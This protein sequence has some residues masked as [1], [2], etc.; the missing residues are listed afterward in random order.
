MKLS[1]A[2]KFIGI[3]STKAKEE[4]PRES[5]FDPST[6]GPKEIYLA[7]EIQGRPDK[8]TVNK[9][10]SRTLM[11]VGIVVSLLLAI[12]GEFF[13][14]LVIG[15]VIFVSYVLSS[16]PSASSKFEV[17]SHGVKFDEETYYWQQLKRFFFMDASG[18]E[19]LAVDTI[20]P[21]PGRLFI[22]FRPADRERIMELLASRLPFLKE[23]PLTAM[24][25]A[26]S[27]IL[28]KFNF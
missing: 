20:N 3:A 7:W 18:T 26:Y 16:T 14:I 4:T 23:Q 24:D 5:A 25:K 6:L 28:D 21:L 1:D 17:S 10:M 15:S 19:L 13:L 27:S 11:V 22:A 8:K 2:A 12:M 9:K